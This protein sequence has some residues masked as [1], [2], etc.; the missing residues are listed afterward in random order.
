[1]AQ[2]ANSLCCNAELSQ[3]EMALLMLHSSRDRKAVTV[4]Q[5]D[6]VQ[7]GGASESDSSI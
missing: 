6:L 4:Q 7:P 5:T 2:H 1:M 3:N